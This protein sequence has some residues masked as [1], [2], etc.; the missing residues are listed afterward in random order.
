MERSLLIDRLLKL[1]VTDRAA[2]S[3][4][5]AKAYFDQHPENFHMPESFSFQSISILPPP[6]ATP[7]QMRKLASAQ[8][9][10]CARP[11]RPRVTKISDVSRENLRRRLPGDDG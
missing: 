1:E 7:A 9:T 3:V 2:V 4:A 10:R 5:E 6:N 8:R 11:R